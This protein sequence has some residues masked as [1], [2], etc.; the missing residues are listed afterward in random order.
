MAID[1]VV[2]S[3][4]VDNGTDDNKIPVYNSTTR[5]FDMETP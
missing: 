5:S 4:K 1:T 2:S 3:I